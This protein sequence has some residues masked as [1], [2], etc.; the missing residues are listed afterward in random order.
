NNV[1]IVG[2]TSAGKALS[3]AELY[4]PW[5]RVFQ[6]IGWLNSPR[7]G[8]TASALPNGKALIAGGS[9]MNAAL[10]SSEAIASATVTANQG[11]TDFSRAML[12]FVGGRGWQPGEQV[13][14]S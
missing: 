12:V 10:A 11:R 8:A 13:N 3:A 1:L 2:G 14:L 5:Q 9:S 4:V 7:A 6:A